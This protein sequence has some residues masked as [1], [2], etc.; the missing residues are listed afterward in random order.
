[1]RYA[2]RILGLAL[3]MTLLVDLA[4]AH[5]VLTGSSPP[6]GGV[7]PQAPP[8]IRLSFN[9]GIEPRFS[10]VTLTRS[11]GKKVPLERPAGDPQKRGDLVVP[12]PSLPAGK[13]QVRWQATSVD[14]HRIQGS[15][16]FEIRP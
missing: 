8:E 10:S 5:S 16:G 2:I 6:N 14:S 11:D 7:L 9:E 12:L 15:F 3:A 1:M 4:A 13:Y